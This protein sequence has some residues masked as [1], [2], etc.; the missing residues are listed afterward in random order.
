MSPVLETRGIRTVGWRALVCPT[1]PQGGQQCCPPSPTASIYLAAEVR[2]LR[3]RGRGFAPELKTRLIYRWRRQ[4]TSGYGGMQAATRKVGVGF[5]GANPGT[6]SGPPSHRRM[7][8]F[9]PFARRGARRG[10]VPPEVRFVVVP[11]LRAVAPRCIRHRC[12]CFAGG[13][14]YLSAV[15][16]GS[17]VPE[18]GC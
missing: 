14:R 10:A 18:A 15:P 11:K 6:R 5:R 3:G 4:S 17:S 8:R 12:I 16:A 1:L 7:C 9:Q 13:A 2:F